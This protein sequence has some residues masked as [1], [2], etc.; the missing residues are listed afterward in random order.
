M[1]KRLRIDGI[2]R[3]SFADERLQVYVVHE[4]GQCEDLPCIFQPLID[5]INQ[6][7]RG[8]EPYG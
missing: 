8:S 3:C 7:G 4:T 5:W 6:V 2:S 1:Q